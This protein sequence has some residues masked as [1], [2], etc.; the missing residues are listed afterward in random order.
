MPGD[1]VSI[2]GVLP[3][4]PTPFLDGRFDSAS[5]Q[6]LLDQMLDH[7]DGY[8]LLGSTGEAPSMTTEER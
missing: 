6:R 3:V 7:V 5:F 2:T 8:T 4:I 1:A